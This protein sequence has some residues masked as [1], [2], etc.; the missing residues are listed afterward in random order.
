MPRKNTPP[1][2][3]LVYVGEFV[4][5][6][7]ERML[8]GELR[9]LEFR[10]FSMHG[11]TAKRRVLHFGLLYAY[12]TWRLTEGPPIPEYLLPLRTRCADLI[13]VSPEELPEALV[14]EYRPGAGIGW[15]RDAPM[16]GTVVGVSLGGTCRMRFQRGKGEQ[17][18]TTEV[19]LEPRSV[20]VLAGPARTEW[21][22]TIPATKELRY[23]IT[24]RTLRPRKRTRTDAEPA[25]HPQ[26]LR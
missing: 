26:Q 11:V 21:Q 8:L 16:F 18:E 9:M 4:S 6:D 15:H 1:P 22:H 25:E 24:L 20:Y 2:E 5:A 12:E 17:R 7:E 10:E 14:T 23:S 3:G 19:L 13:G